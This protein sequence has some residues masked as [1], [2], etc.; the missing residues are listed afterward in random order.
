MRVVARGGLVLDVRRCDRDPS[1]ALLGGLVD[2]V[3]GDG[4]GV[5]GLGEDLQFREC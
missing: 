1:G 3:K 4:L 2:L 5:A